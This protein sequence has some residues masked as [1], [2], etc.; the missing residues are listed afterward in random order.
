MPFTLRSFDL[1]NSLFSLLA[2]QRLK[3]KEELWKRGRA[4]LS[5]GWKEELEKNYPKS[6]DHRSFYFKQA[7]KKQVSGKALLM[8][9]KTLVE[10]AQKKQE[11]NPRLEVSLHTWWCAG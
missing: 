5:K 7:D 3:E 6:L 11:P 2:A 1:G 8:Q 4:E 10:E 9:M